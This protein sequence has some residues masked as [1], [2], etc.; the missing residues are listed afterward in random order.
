MKVELNLRD[1]LPRSASI[2][3]R[4]IRRRCEGNTLEGRYRKLCQRTKECL[5]AQAT[6]F[7]RN[8][9]IH[10]AY[11]NILELDPI[12]KSCNLEVC[13]H[14]Y[15]ATIPGQ[16]MLLYVSFTLYLLFPVLFSRC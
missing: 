3:L 7:L 11:K 1:G 16:L 14:Y 15:K 4:L 12:G 5:T 10:E 8:K 13:I 2:S 9:R 6:V